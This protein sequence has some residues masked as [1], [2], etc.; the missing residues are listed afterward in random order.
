MGNKVVAK[1]IIPMEAVESSITILPASTAG[2]HPVVS[3]EAVVLRQM[4]MGLRLCL[5]RTQVSSMYVCTQWRETRASF[6]DENQALTLP[7][8]LQ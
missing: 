5:L 1:W 6:S 2:K 8:P 4:M 7:F 3:S